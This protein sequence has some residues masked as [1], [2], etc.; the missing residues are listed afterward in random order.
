LDVTGGLAGGGI[1][2][3]LIAGDADL[4]LFI[5]SESPDGWYAFGGCPNIHGFDVIKK[6]WTGKIAATYPVYS[7]AI[8][9]AAV[10]N[11]RTNG[12]NYDVQTMWFG[13]SFGSIRDDVSTT[14]LDRVHIASDVFS[15]MQFPTTPCCPAEAGVPRAYKLSQ[16]F[17]NPFNPRTSIKFDMKEKG[18]VTVRI[19]NV[20][21]QLVRTLIDGVKDA[22][23]YSVTWD[24]T[25]NLG[26]KVGS[27]IY[28]SK[29]E[30]REYSATRK[31]VLLR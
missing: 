15:W 9:P 18:L 26:V 3:P 13:F 27:G 16:N 10:G 11:Q 6:M 8:Q 2:S 22:G 1:A 24:G 5:H 12:G 14:V 17:P 31:L 29:M 21:G 7:S 30:T 25:N 4:G 19:Y 28:F 23:S 20:A